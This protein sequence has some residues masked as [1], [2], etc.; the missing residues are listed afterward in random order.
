MPSFPPAGQASESAA[1]VAVSRATATKCW[2]ALE[3]RP[4]LQQRQPVLAID[5]LSARPL[6]G[7]AVCNAATPPLG[8][9]Q[10]LQPDSEDVAGRVCARC[11]VGQL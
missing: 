11:T 8:R 4:L 7:P 6:A 3:A 2:L 9:M 1:V 10:R 5:C